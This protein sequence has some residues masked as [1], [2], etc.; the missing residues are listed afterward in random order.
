MDTSCSNIMRLWEV[1]PVGVADIERR[2]RPEGGTFL[3]CGL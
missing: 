3:P 1:F 2:G